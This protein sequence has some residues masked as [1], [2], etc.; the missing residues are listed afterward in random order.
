MRSQTISAGL[1]LA[2]FLASCG[3]NVTLKLFQLALVSN[4]ELWLS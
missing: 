3:A 1:L 4:W 2:V